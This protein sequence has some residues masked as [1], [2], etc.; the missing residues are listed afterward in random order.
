[1][2]VPKSILN[3]PRADCDTLDRYPLLE[4]CAPRWLW[5]PRCWFPSNLTGCSSAA[6]VEDCSH[7]SD[8][9]LSVPQGQV[10]E[11]SSLTILSAHVT[12][13]TSF[14]SPPTP[15]SFLATL[16]RCLRGISSLT[17]AKQKAVSPSTPSPLCFLPIQWHLTTPFL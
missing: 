15:G 1:M 6:S 3:G 11:V 8:L 16:I 9:Q 2:T 12:F 13:H 5:T 14:Q 4:T 10:P 7:L 17:H